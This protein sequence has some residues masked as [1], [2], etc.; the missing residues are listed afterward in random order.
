MN[1]YVASSWRNEQQPAVVAALRTAGHEVYDFRDPVSA[2]HWADIDPL[3]K[4]W[5]P[6][7]FREALKHPL[8]RRGFNKDFEALEQADVCVLVQPCG[9]S[10]HL[11][12]GWAVAAGL[13]TIVLLSSGE[14]ELMYSMADQL[15]VSIT[16]VVALLDALEDE[17]KP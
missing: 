5:S 8:A 3:W 12:L 15:A 9:I 2:F 6:W 4:D 14:P 17:D 1:V 16:E 11:E 13:R 7:Q 10:A